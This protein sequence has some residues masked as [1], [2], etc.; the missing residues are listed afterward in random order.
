MISESES[1]GQN[2]LEVISLVCPEVTKPQEALVKFTIALCVSEKL[3]SDKLH[4][5]PVGFLRALQKPGCMGQILEQTRVAEIVFGGGDHFFDLGRCSLY[6]AGLDGAS[7]EDCPLDDA[8]WVAA[9]TAARR[10]VT[11]L[12]EETE[13]S[14]VFRGLRFHNNGEVPRPEANRGPDD[15]T[16]DPGLYAYRHCLVEVE[17]V[18]SNASLTFPDG[19][20]VAEIP[21]AVGRAVG[22]YTAHGLKSVVIFAQGKIRS[23][24]LRMDP[25]R[26]GGWQRRSGDRS[27]N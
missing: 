5:V 15:E 20:E 16:G 12:Y 7:I 4:H 22:A 11:V 19:H 8:A 23:L 6:L 2:E 18:G 1:E 25:D 3:I 21:A 27:K 10:P 13:G 14:R 9:Q 26:E 17:V 24:R